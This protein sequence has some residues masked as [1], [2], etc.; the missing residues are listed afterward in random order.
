[1]KTITEHLESAAITFVATFA[2]I[3]GLAISDQSFTFS[4]ET[5]AA[6]AIAALTVAV[7]ATALIIVDF[8]KSFMAQPTPTE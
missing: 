5:L 3:F 8:A 6:A 2:V 4:R 7:R 1:M